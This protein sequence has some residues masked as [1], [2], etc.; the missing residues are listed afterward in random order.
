MIYNGLRRGRRYIVTIRNAAGRTECMMEYDSLD[1][2]FKILE[3][4]PPHDNR[5][6]EIRDTRPESEIRPRGTA[7]ENDDT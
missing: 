7:N 5:R 1:E 3:E 4:N 6:V 2:V